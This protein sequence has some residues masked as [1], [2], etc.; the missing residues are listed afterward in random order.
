MWE[1]LKFADFLK[2][3]KAK[4]SQQPNLGSLTI[5]FHQNTPRGS[6]R[7]VWNEWV[8]GKEEAIYVANLP[9]GR[10]RDLAYFM[11]KGFEAAPTDREI[12]A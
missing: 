8:N 4:A 3:V 6:L 9:I 5:H 12:Y 11:V 10:I 7:L 1:Q 2:L